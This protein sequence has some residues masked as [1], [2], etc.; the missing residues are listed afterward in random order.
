M[1]FFIFKEKGSFPIDAVAKGFLPLGIVYTLTLFKAI[2][3]ALQSLSIYLYIKL[4]K[5]IHVPEISQ[6]LTYMQDYKFVLNPTR[7]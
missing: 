1:F 2:K 5:S 7:T 3:E 6:K 4:I